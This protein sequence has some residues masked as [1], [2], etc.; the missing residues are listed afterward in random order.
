M[1]PLHARE[2]L[3]MMTNFAYMASSEELKLFWF[4]FSEMFGKGTEMYSDVG[5]IEGVDGFFK[6]E[7]Y[8]HYYHAML[9]RNILNLGVVQNYLGL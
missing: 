6:P 8:E 1:T 2:Y 7:D 9:D 4:N 5:P 3:I